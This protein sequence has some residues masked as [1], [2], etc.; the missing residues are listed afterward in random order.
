MVAVAFSWV[1]SDLVF[2]ELRA[3]VQPGLDTRPDLHSG[4]RAS[5]VGL[6]H[7]PLRGPPGRLTATGAYLAAGVLYV[8]AFVFADPVTFECADCPG[9]SFLIADDKPLSDALASP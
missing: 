8:A 6:S 5:P 2:L 9:N 7:G 1:V 4:D 3:A